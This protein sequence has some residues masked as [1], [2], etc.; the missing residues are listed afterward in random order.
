MSEQPDGE[1]DLGGPLSVAFLLLLF[2][3]VVGGVLWWRLPNPKN[4]AAFGDAFGG[5]AGTL[6]SG[7]ALV[8]LIFT[9]LQQQRALRLQREQLSLQREELRETRAELRRT[10]DAQVA[11]EKALQKQVRAS[12]ISAQL[13]AMT[14]LMTFYREE[15]IRAKRGGTSEQ[16]A[17]ARE[18]QELFSRQ[19]W[20]LLD[21]AGENYIS[22]GSK[23]PWPPSDPRNQ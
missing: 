8:L 2:L 20:T 16:I 10:A 4:V 7:F 19:I 14:A 13:N 11:S 15:E 6:V 23:G 3:V 22:K 12:Q 5:V 9:V 17:E 1:R 18:W 21:E